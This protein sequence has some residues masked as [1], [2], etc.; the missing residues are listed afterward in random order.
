[1]TVVVELR[2]LFKNFKGLSQLS[3]MA[4]NIQPTQLSRMVICNHIK[5]FFMLVAQMKHSGCLT[6]E[7]ELA[8]YAHFQ[9]KD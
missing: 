8:S 3:S 2:F 4:I 1:M 7:Y 5:E 6:L 9:L